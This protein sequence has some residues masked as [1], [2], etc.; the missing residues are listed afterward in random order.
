[1]YVFAIEMSGVCNSPFKKEISTW[2][3]SSAGGTRINRWMI[4][5]A[6]GLTGVVS[7]AAAKSFHGHAKAHTAAPAQ[8]PSSPSFAPASR[9]CGLN[10]DA[11]RLPNPFA[12]GARGSRGPFS[13]M[14]LLSFGRKQGLPMTVADST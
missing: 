6:L 5:V 3:F 12:C 2:R 4:A 7:V 14:I 10:F 1:M 11:G 13:R 9:S 8:P